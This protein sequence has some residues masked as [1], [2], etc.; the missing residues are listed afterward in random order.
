MRAEAPA[1]VDKAAVARRFNRSALTY[2]SA[3]RVQRSMAGRLMAALDQAVPARI[4]ELGCGTGYL[5]RL[6]A[7]RYPGAAIL[8]VDFAGRMVEVARHRVAGRRVEFMVADA[9]SAGFGSG[10]DLVISNATIQWF[11]TPAETLSRLGSGLS[12]GGRMLHSTF[13]P[14]TFGEL[15]QVFAEAAGEAVGLPLRSAGGWAG[16]VGQAGL[17]AEARRRCELVRY[18]T[19]ADFLRELQ[20]TGATW[21][22]HSAGAVPAPPGLLRQAIARYDR[23]F[24][25]GDGVPVT[26]ELIE[27][28]GRPERG[29][30]LNGET[31]VG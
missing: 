28:S 5:T 16:I 10:W 23:R 19:A 1:R 30:P 9:E 17:A 13:G 12:P 8:A 7:E 29:R 31:K 3:C 26:Y 4:L 2:D 22:P 21:R 14:Q 24:G 25:A 6:L 27:V 20:A 15:R 18:P 11:C